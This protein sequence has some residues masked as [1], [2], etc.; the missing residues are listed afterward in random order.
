VIAVYRSRGNEAFIEGLIVL[1]V[2]LVLVLENKTEDEDENEDDRM[3]T[4][5]AA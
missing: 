5:T 3:L 1:V 2:V 4:P